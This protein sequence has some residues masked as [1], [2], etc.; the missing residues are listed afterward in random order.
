M[1]ACASVIPSKN[2]TQMLMLPWLCLEMFLEPLCLSNFNVADQYLCCLEP[3]AVDQRGLA[4]Q[5]STAYE[6]PGSINELP[7]KLLTT[8]FLPKEHFCA[9]PESQTQLK[10]WDIAS[11]S[12]CFSSLMQQHEQ[13]P[14]LWPLIYQ[15]PLPQVSVG[16]LNL[17]SL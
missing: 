5:I 1:L 10:A 17:L 12:L 4:G 8:F 13:L 2:L 6:C 7:S 16:V 15:Q 14:L 3:C 9:H 11:F